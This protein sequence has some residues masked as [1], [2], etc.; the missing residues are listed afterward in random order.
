MNAK[1]KDARQLLENKL[2]QEIFDAQRHETV[3]RFAQAD[4]DDVPKLVACNIEMS[5]LERLRECIHEECRRIIDDAGSKSAA[6][7]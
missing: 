3:E 1:E 4:S 7:T 6:D 5:A 2:L